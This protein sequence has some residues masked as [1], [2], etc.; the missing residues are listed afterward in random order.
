MEFGLNSES[1]TSLRM[2]DVSKMEGKTDFR[3]AYGL[4]GSGIVEC[5]EIGCN[6]TVRCLDVTKGGS[7]VGERLAIPVEYKLLRV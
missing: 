5:L 3:G 6:L 4:S 2:K 7:R 1:F